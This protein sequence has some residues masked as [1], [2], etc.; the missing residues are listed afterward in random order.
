MKLSGID[1]YLWVCI[2]VVALHLI[3]GVWASAIY[4]MPIG[5]D[6]KWHRSLVQAIV[7]RGPS[8]IVDRVF[9]S[10][11]EMPYPP[12]YHFLFVLPVYLGYQDLFGR[13]LQVFLFSATLSVL[14]LVAYRWGGGSYYAMCTA[15]FLASGVGFWDRGF[16]VAPQ[17]FEMLFL[18]V[19]IWAFLGEHPVAFVLSALGMVYMHAPVAWILLAPF[20][21]L[22]LLFRAKESCWILSLFGIFLGSIPLAMFL[23]PYAVSAT[24][25]HSGLLS[26]QKAFMYSRPILFTVLY[27]GPAFILTAHFLLR[28]RWHKLWDL[29]KLMAVLAVS[30][31]ALLPLWADRAL[32]YAVMPLSFLIPFAMGESK[33]GWMLV[34]VAFAVWGVLVKFLMVP[35]MDV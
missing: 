24:V 2:I 22:V 35:V 11:G 8:A 12:L 16:Q 33:R 7:E 30:L 14:I 17:G 28:L 4:P 13:I 31:L 18:A 34:V 27:L 20:F 15:L 29:H 25:K 19:A 3:V 26:A 1:R 9:L 6:Y 23:A 5:Q 32:G 21:V 10:A